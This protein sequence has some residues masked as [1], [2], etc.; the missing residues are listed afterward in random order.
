MHFLFK[1]VQTAG[2][3]SF[4]PKAYN[5]VQKV[6]GGEGV[7]LLLNIAEIFSRLCGLKQEGGISVEMYEYVCVC[8]GGGGQTTK[9]TIIAQYNRILGGELSFPLKHSYI[10]SFERVQNSHQPLSESSYPAIYLE[11]NANEQDVI[12]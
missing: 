8:V 6:L 1:S 7:K 11:I 2:N 12:R 3:K 10:H 5:K 4:F 9:Y